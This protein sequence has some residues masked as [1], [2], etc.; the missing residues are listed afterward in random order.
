MRAV[1][2]HGDP[3]PA[4]MKA[5]KCYGWIGMDWVD[6]D[7]DCNDDDHHDDDDGRAHSR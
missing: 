7:H 2:W 5:P 3:D 6:S 4:K 1:L